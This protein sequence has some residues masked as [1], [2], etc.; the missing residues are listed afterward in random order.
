MP[1]VGLNLLDYLLIFILFLG[2]V[3]G[4]LRGVLPQ[5]ISVASIWFGLLGSLWLYRPLSN[6]ILQGLGFP[7]IGS[8]TMAFLILLIVFFH[9]IRLI[10]KAVTVPPEEKKKKPRRKGR[11]GPPEE[12]LVVK[13][14]TQKY[15]SGPFQAFGGIF[16]GVLLTALW[17]ALILGVLQFTFQ[18]N[19]G[20][21]AEGAATGT[22]SA[23]RGIAAQLHGSGLLGYFNQILRLVVR[24]LS[25]F[26]FNSTPN[27]LEVVINR[28][29]P[30]G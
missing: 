23:G 10:V 27:I 8:D 20:E 28:L 24:S 17:T 26:E 25:L 30:P 22:I 6:N 14:A 18:V 13:T 16:L 1:N 3:V 5:I 7:K 4:F 29:F 21:A 12:D 19:V 15:I 9:A 11:V 2:A